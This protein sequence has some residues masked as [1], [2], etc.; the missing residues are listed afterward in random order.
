MKQN[1]KKPKKG[2]S[3]IFQNT[4]CSLLGK[5]FSLQKASCILPYLARFKQENISIEFKTKHKNPGELL[6]QVSGMYKLML[7]D[8]I[9]LSAL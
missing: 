8:T 4:F 9:M 3:D 7:L 6:K 5:M 1:W 2:D